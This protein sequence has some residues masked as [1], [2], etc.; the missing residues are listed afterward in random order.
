MTDIEHISLYAVL[1]DV[2]GENGI[3]RNLKNTLVRDAIAKINNGF[4]EDCRGE[5]DT[6]EAYVRTSN[7][8]EL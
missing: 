2:V 1:F 5:G 6:G 3:V 8:E 4:I 7:L